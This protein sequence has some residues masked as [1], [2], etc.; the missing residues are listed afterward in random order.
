MVQIP[1]HRLED[2]ARYIDLTLFDNPAL[3]SLN[4]TTREP[5]GER[6]AFENEPRSAES[7]RRSQ[8]AVNH[9]AREYMRRV[10]VRVS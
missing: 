1:R 3:S 2:L 7:A 8:V 4:K 9:I 5:S 6:A 10:S